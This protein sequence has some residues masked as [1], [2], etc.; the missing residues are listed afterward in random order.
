MSSAKSQ[1]IFKTVIFGLGNIGLLYDIKNTSPQREAHCLTHAKALSRSKYFQL[2]A[3]VDVNQNNRNLFSTTYNLPSY[4][5]ISELSNLSQIAL[6][7]VALP[8]GNQV[9]ECLRLLNNLIP[10][11]LLI[12]K[13]VGVSSIES[14]E[15]LAWAEK[16]NVTIFV[17]YFRNRFESAI[18]ARR[19]LAELN[20]GKIIKVKVSSY[21]SLRNIFCHFLELS[22]FLLPGNVFCLCTK[23]ILHDPT[24]SSLTVKCTFC[25]R[26]YEFEGINSENSDSEVEITGEFFRLYILQ[27]GR[28]IRIESINQEFAQ[29]FETPLEE[30][31][32]YQQKFYENL[33]FEI[34][35][36]RRN[37]DLER[38]ILVQEFIDDI[39]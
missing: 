35:S 37:E 33:Y 38:A 26:I 28:T 12:E 2:V 34:I 10:R 23:D 19:T 17:N 13:P 6:L 29:V 31:V 3:G 1:P 39:E 8:T 21:G 4:S 20:F 16:N 11:Y 30:F 15:L 14:K 7:V 18:N 5:D 9:S 22:E 32:Q 24:V 36:G 25:F 27:N